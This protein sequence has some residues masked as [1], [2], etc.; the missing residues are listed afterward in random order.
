MSYLAAAAWANTG[1]APTTGVSKTT[2]E[3]S[4]EVVDLTEEE[5]NYEKPVPTKIKED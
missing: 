4:T 3:L 1:L 2:G 5:G